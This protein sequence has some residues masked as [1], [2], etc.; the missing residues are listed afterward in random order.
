MGKLGHRHPH[1]GNAML[2][3]C[4]DEGDAS[5]SP[6]TPKIAS[7]HQNLGTD[8]PSWP[9]NEP[10]LLASWPQ[11]SASQTGAEE[12]NVLWFKPC[13]VWYFD[14]AAPA[15][16]NSQLNFKCSFHSSS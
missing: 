15:D 7:K 11:T 6:G 13:H 2:H 8:P 16:Q 3:E 4:R 12:I 5:A 10:A 14:T 9:Q 1:K